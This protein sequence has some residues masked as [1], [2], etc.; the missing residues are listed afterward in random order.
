M[1]EPRGRG[2]AVAVLLVAVGFVVAPLSVFGTASR[3]GI[4]VVIGTGILATFLLARGSKSMEARQ[5]LLTVMLMAVGVR[6]V[7]LAL[8]HQSV[9]PIVFAP[10]ALVYEEVGQQLLQSWQGLRP[11]PE[12]ASGTQFGYYAMNAVFFFFFGRGVGA[13]VAFNILLAS[14]LA[15]PVYYLTLAVVRGQH[16]VA[17]LATMYSPFRRSCASVVEPVGAA[18]VAKASAERRCPTQV[19]PAVPPPHHPPYP[20]VP[21]L[22]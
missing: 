18:A 6:L 16:A 22:I 4:P 3:V 15:V 9:G 14:W 17:R 1:A 5:F 8:I 10:D 7:V 13:P 11:L 12:K 21:F 19:Q 20:T 2:F